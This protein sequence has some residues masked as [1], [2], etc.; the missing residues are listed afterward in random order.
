MRTERVRARTPVSA[1]RDVCGARG[2]W[3]AGAG[4][5]VAGMLSSQRDLVLSGHAPQCPEG[6]KEAA[7]AAK[8]Y[9][10]RGRSSFQM[11]RTLEDDAVPGHVHTGAV[12][13]D[14]SQEFLRSLPSEGTLACMLSVLLGPEPESCSFLST[15][16]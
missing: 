14:V 2:F 15:R 7:S 1:L 16:I 5:N 6:G 9:P 10:A 13:A 12:R 11:S 4:D 8:L 3:G